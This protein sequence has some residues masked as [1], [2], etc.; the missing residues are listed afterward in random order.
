MGYLGN[1]SQSFYDATSFAP[2]SWFNCMLHVRFLMR[3]TDCCQKMTCPESACF[4]RY[5]SL[6][7]PSI[8]LI[9]CLCLSKPPLHSCTQ[10]LNPTASTSMLDKVL[11]PGLAVTSVYAAGYATYASRLFFFTLRER[12][13]ANAR[14]ITRAST[15]AVIS[16]RQQTHVK[17]GGPL[18]SIVCCIGC[19]DGSIFLRPSMRHCGKR[20]IQ[21]ACVV[22]L[23]SVVDALTVCKSLM[24]GPWF[25]ACEQ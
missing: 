5:I 23:R 21:V 4:P 17:L 12:T 14:G 16:C 19:N 9:P 3:F 15:A 7:Q 13:C 8:A 10:T 25:Y 1:F 18:V 6:R 20:M 11:C 2:T 24:F 22:A